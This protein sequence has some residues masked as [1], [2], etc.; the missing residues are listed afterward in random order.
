MTDIKLNKSVFGNDTY[1]N[2]IDTKFEQLLKENTE[3]TPVPTIEEF[4]NLYEILFYSIPKEG[5]NSH[6][7][8][9]N[10]SSEY[11]GLNTEQSQIDV[12]S[13]VEEINS[14]QKELLEANK[15]IVEL[16]LQSIND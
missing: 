12:N 15:T 14:L 5:D 7:Y 16:R 9:I 10:Q 4:F 13:L 3:T 6:E 8:L 2:V 1:K 11:L